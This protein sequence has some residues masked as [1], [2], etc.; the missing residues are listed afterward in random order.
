MRD[1]EDCKLMD[2]VK[3]EIPTE[4]KCLR[5]ESFTRKERH[6]FVVY[7]DFECLTVPIHTCELDLP[8]ISY[9]VV[10]GVEYTM[11]CK[12]NDMYPALL[13]M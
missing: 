3:I 12:I 13:F 9:T 2:A 7:P 4:D 6:P 1:E 5:F 10:H 8:D 11:L